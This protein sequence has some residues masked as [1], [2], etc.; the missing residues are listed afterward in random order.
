MN[1]VP[2]PSPGATMCLELHQ[3]EIADSGG[4]HNK[5]CKYSQH[6]EAPKI[7]PNNLVLI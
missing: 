4:S 1:Q 6:I 3:E 2:V 7:G 5:G